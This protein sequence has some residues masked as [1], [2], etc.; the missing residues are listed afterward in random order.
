MNQLV[1]DS[2]VTNLLSLVIA[3]V[4]SRTVKIMSK[5]HSILSLSAEL[6]LGRKGVVASIAHNAVRGKVDWE[7]IFKRLSTVVACMPGE[8]LKN[9][10]Y[11]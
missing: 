7:L 3:S 4:Q 1:N 5:K 10:V 11:N 8:G 9:V 6:D 2:I